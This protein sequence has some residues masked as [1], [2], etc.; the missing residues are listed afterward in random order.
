M[1][2]T[3]E[4]LLQAVEERRQEVLTIE[5]ELGAPYSQEYE[6]AKAELKQAEA[7]KMMSGQTEFM[8]DNLDTLHA[9]V[10]SLRPESPSVFVKF[11]KLS[12]ADWALL[13]KQAIPNPIDQ[14][15]KV[16]PKTFVGVFASEDAEQPLTEDY[17]AVSSK[18]NGSILPGGTLHALIQS[19][20]AWQNSGG[21]VSIR[22]TKSVRG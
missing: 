19:F 16:L 5:V 22:P 21:E 17:H 9:K 2:S 14:Y 15:E 12:V 3:Y 10:D 7:I 4:E 8:S 11:R 18:G 20:M 13:L 6:D 1:F